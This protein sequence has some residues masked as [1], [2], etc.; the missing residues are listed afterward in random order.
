MFPLPAVSQVRS[1]ESLES[2]RCKRFNI[3]V[4]LPDGLVSHTDAIPPVEKSFCN[5]I[6]GSK[7]RGSN[8]LRQLVR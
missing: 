7:E 8:H 6:T 3:Q 2:E 1:H 4:G 5:A